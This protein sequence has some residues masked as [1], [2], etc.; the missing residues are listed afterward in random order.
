MRIKK[1]DG[2]YIDIMDEILKAGIIQV[3]KAAIKKQVLTY[4]P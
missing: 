1:S 2:Q 4:G 3:Q